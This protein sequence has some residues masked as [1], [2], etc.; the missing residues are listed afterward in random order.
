MFTTRAATKNSIMSIRHIL[1]KNVPGRHSTPVLH[2]AIVSELDSKDSTEVREKSG[3]FERATRPGS[4]RL[5]TQSHIDSPV[6]TFQSLDIQE[7][8]RPVHHLGSSRYFA[9]TVRTQ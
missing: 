1:R 6:M 2:T 7:R 3:H 4:T 8:V 9:T 5:V